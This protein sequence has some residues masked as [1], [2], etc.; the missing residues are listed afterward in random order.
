MYC[1]KCGKFIGNEADLCDECL[2]KDGE[3]FSEFSKEDKKELPPLFYQPPT[4][5]PPQFT[6]SENKPIALGKSIA[7]VIL[8]TV[9]FVLVY[10]AIMIFGVM[11]ETELYDD[12]LAVGALVLMVI[13]IIPCVLGLVFGI[14]S[15]SRFKATSAVK[16]GKRIPLLILG[17]VS[18][19]QG[20]MGLVI[21]F[22]FL[23]TA[24]LV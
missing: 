2:S 7:A 19:A 22:I 12:G 1:K 15:I 6:N 13:S 10:A 20:G 17:I 8:S 5:T 11:A 3:V 23:S 16:S 18:I 9:G 21:V 4:Y 14:Q 24:L